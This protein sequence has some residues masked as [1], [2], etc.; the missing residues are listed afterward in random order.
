LEEVE[1]KV[2]DLR[3]L[4]ERYD[5]AE[6][7]L[8]NEIEL[9]RDVRVPGLHLANEEMCRQIEALIALNV[10]KQVAFDPTSGKG[11]HGILD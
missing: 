8:N 10:G 9:Y 6:E 11:N 5:K 7:A 2:D 3:L 4:I 1:S